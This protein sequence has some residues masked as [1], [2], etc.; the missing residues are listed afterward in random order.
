MLGRDTSRHAG[1]IDRKLKGVDLHGGG[2]RSPGRGGGGRGWPDG[3]MAWGPE[4]PP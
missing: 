4:A 2:G 3:C 1:P